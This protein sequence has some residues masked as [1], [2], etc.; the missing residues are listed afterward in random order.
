[1][2]KTW[3]PLSGDARAIMVALRLVVLLSLYVALRDVLVPHDPQMTDWPWTSLLVMH[4]GF[5]LTMFI[6][7]FGV[8]FFTMYPFWKRKRDLFPG[9]GHAFNMSITPMA[10]LCAIILISEMESSLWQLGMR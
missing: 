2:G 6:I 1:M 9:I 5:P 10:F 4:V 3:Y 8:V 7:L